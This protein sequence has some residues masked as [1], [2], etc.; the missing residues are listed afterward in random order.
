MNVTKL[1][2]LALALAGL[3]ALFAKEYPSLVRYMKIEKM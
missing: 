2:L 1:V 3:G